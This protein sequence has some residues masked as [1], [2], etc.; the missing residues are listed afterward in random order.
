MRKIIK[1][2]YQKIYFSKTIKNFFE[3]NRSFGI[4]YKDFVRLKKF[5]MQ[6]TNDDVVNLFNKKIEFSSPFWFLHS[7]QEIFVDEVYKFIPSKEN[8]LILDCGANIGLSTIYLKHIFPNSKIIAYEPDQKVFAQLKNNLNQFNYSDIE[9]QNKAIWIKDGYINFLSE[10]ALGG[11]I[12]KKPN[13]NNLTETVS[14]KKILQN[15]NV[16]FLKMDIEG[17]EYEVLKDIKDE[18]KKVENLFIEFHVEKN[19]E[20][21]LAELLHM[22]DQAGF[23]YYIKDAWNNMKHPFTKNNIGGFHLQLNIFCYRTLT[24]N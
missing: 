9:L 18:I 21:H 1:K 23:T 10:G 5:S 20:N 19:E 16:F 24:K 7:L 14:L 3:Y 13:Q 11:K 22:I 8:H 12:D 6:A 4:S 17:A 15:N 2:I